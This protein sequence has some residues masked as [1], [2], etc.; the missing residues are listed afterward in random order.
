VRTKAKSICFVAKIFTLL[1]AIR[2]GYLKGCPNLTAKGV[3][4]YLNQSP[5]TVKGHMKCPRQGIRSTQTRGSLTNATNVTTADLP[6]IAND[7]DDNDNLS[8]FTPQG[9][10]PCSNANVV[11]A[12][13]GSTKDVT[14]FVLFCGV[15]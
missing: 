14:L 3:S 5:A 6:I 15:C 8:H 9:D 12:D 7:N 1:K 13:D 4:K 10:N 2:C 11:K